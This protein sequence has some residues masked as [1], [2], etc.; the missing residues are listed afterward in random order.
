MAVA[1]LG[2]KCKI[3]IL[4]LCEGDNKNTFVDA[5]LR[6]L[7]FYS[8]TSG[9]EITVIGDG[10][11][12]SEFKVNS[13]SPESACGIKNF[14]VSLP[15]WYREQLSALFF[16]AYS[17]GEYTLILPTGAFAIAPICD[18]S[19]L[20]R[21]KART[22]WEPRSYHPDWW[23]NAGEATHRT[24]MSPF[25]GPTVFPG[26]MNRDLARWTLD[27]VSRESGREP[28]DALTELSLSGIDWSAMS[29]YATAS[30]SRFSLYHHD[31]FASREYPLMS[32]QLLWAPHNQKTFQPALRSKANG[33]LFT[34]VHV[35]EL[36][37]VDDVL[38]RLY[39][40]LKP[41]RYNLKLNKESVVHEEPNL[42]I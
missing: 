38:D 17:G 18:N 42:G 9:M 8:P 5:L 10:K 30:G 23:K 1:D 29:L 36:E 11:I 20:P 37:D 22:V 35:S 7:S 25:E 33:G 24:A 19:L 41:N 4:S 26:I 21:L 15:E 31:A 27:I 2:M 14:A 6:S 3:A 13:L 12:S 39:A 34:Y 32:E 28:I 16:A 40:C